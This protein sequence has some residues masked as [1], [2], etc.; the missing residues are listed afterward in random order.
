M[1]NL[2]PFAPL[3]GSRVGG[4]VLYAWDVHTPQEPNGPGACGVTWD[5]DNAV[6]GLSGALTT[7]PHGTYGTVRKVTPS[8]F[9][10]VTYQD[11]G[12]LGDARRTGRGVSW[13]AHDPT[14]SSSLR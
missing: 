1:G 14:L 12:M 10:D 3:R 2:S 9:G 5:R 6:K 8:L 13:V 11:L 7:F 4:P